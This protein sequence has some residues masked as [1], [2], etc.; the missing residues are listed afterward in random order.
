MK[1]QKYK[2][3]VLS[4]LKDTTNNVLKNT[5]NLSKVIDGEINFFHVKKPTDVVERE[6][7]LS[8]FR[9]ISEKH[10]ITKKR[11]EEFVSHTKGNYGVT[12]NYSYTFGNVKNEIEDY[13]NKHNPDIIV[14]GKRKSNPFRLGDN[15]TDFVL[16]TFKG[17]ILI[18]GNESTIEFNDQLSLGFLDGK[19]PFLN[20]DFVNELFER[21]KKPLKSF[22][23]VSKGDNLLENNTTT[24]FKTVEYVFERSGNTVQNLTNYLSK[25]KVDLLLIDGNFKENNN[26]GL[27]QPDI[28]SVINQLDISLLISNQKNFSKTI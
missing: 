2:I 3:L 6:S 21:T 28:K 23:V 18:S 25:S 8:T 26:E 14:L 17:I 24:E 4:D 9:T 7:Q 16:N 10:T 22:K 11:I 20:I 12:I 5:A 15:V 1:N 19:N 27:N 13:I